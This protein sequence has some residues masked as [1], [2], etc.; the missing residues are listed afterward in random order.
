MGVFN[1]SIFM[2]PYYLF[3][4][5]VAGIPW[6]LQ[7]SPAKRLPTVKAFFKALRENEGAHLGI[8]AAG[9]CWGGKHVCSLGANDVADQVDGKPLFDAGFTAHPSFLV[10]PKDIEAL[11]LPVSFAIGDKDIQ[12]KAVQIPE[13]QKIVEAKPDY[14]KGEVTMYPGAGHG[15]AVRADHVLTDAKQQADEAEEQC[16]AW[17][18]RHFDAVKY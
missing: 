4:A 3:W 10:V 2:K 18:Q 1:G 8:G 5:L 12:V 11:K 16:I 15:F 6:S 7:N 9:F 13:I 17:F 14:A